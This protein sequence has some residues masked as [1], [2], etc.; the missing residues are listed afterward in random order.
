MDFKISKLKFFSVYPLM[1][2]ISIVSLILAGCGGVVPGPPPR[3][4][5][6][7][8]SDGA[9]DVVRKR[10]VTVTFS[11]KMHPQTITANTFTLSDGTNPV[12]GVV[13]YCGVTAIFAPDAALLPLTQYTA[14]VTGGQ[15]TWRGT[16]SVGVFPGHLQPA[17]LL[18]LFLQRSFRLFRV[19]E[20]PPC[21]RIVQLRPPSASR[22]NR[23]QLLIL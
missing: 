3:V 9:D 13:S 14:T 5:A 16:N 21:R 11:E 8:P 19:T 6:T 20:R 22:W 4:S 23:P 15:P 17:S 18:V 12:A 2:M 1:A 7:S 10:A